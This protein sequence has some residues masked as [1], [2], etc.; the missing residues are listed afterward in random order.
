MS[1]KRQQEPP[2]PPPVNQAE[3]AALRA[4]AEALARSMA[5]RDH[6]AD[7]QRGRKT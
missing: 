3:K 4:L 2:K 5:Q 6:I 7:E 1:L